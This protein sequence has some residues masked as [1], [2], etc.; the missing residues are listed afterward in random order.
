MCAFQGG[1]PLRLSLRVLVAGCL[2]LA[3]F[4]A[5]CIGHDAQIAPQAGKR[6]GATPADVE[7][8]AQI[9]RAD[10]I[11]YLH[12]VAENAR[13]LSEY[14]VEFTRYERR[15]LFQQMHG[16]EHIKCWFRREPFSIKMKWLDKN[17]KY[18]ESVYIQGEYDDKV[19][20][21]TRWWVPP[22]KAPP[23]INTV[24]VETPVIWGESRRPI[25]QFGLA[26]LMERTLG[27]IEKAGKEVMI[28]YE[29]I[30]Q[31]P[32][33]GP[34]VHHFHIEVPPS[35]TD[36]PVQELYIHVTDNLPSGTILKTESG[37]IEAAY[38]YEK[39]DTNVDLTDADFQFD[40]PSD[41]SDKEADAGQ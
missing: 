14:T 29:G 5:G 8:S 36:V 20:F 34:T 17:V 19:R 37:R 38:Y 12:E 39:L 26:K 6:K 7:T 31:L 22:L 11:K 10:P 2:S 23:A 18:Y 27:A 1:L 41:E 4:A 15:G 24:N 40:P 30:A 9:V 13:K 35:Q 16:P 33:D 21:I 32:N 25:T 28:S 3:V